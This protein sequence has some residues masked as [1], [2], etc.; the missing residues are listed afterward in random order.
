MFIAYV[1]VLVGYIYTDTETHRFSLQGQ[2]AF[3][4]F[5]LT[6]TQQLQKAVDPE[7]SVDPEVAS[8]ENGPTAQRPQSSEM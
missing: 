7:V 1:Y 4:H 8:K 3:P 2:K 6:L 5:L